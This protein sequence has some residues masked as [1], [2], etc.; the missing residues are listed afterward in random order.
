LA[1]D[2][3]EESRNAFPAPIATTG[4][5]RPLQE[6]EREYLTAALAC[7]DGNQTRTAVQLK[8]GPATLYRKFKSYGL[9]ADRKESQTPT[10]G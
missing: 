3:P 2:L 7:N 1:L 10:V 6:V 9:I 5:V 4:T 8:I